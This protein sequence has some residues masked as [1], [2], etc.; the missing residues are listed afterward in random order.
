MG[1][2]KVCGWNRKLDR[3][4]NATPFATVRTISWPLSLV[5]SAF[6]PRGVL[7]RPCLPKDAFAACPFK[8]H[9]A[10]FDEAS[11][12]RPDRRALAWWGDT[13]DMLRHR[14]LRNPRY[15]R[16]IFEHAGGGSSLSDR[17]AALHEPRASQSSCAWTNC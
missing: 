6:V 7:S 13:L 3:C 15:N 8:P 4:A 9:Y 14:L 10:I 16:E 2:L 12:L 11:Y 17:V 5:N 1:S